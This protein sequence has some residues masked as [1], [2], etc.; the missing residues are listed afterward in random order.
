MLDLR[1][2]SWWDAAAGSAKV[3][4]LVSARLL[5]C[6][7]R[8]GVTSR[9]GSPIHQLLLSL[10]RIDSGVMHADSREFS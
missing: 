8:V 4:A 5:G 2:E 10:D 6:L 3:A 1:C 9:V 7:G